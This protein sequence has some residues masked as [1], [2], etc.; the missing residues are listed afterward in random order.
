MASSSKGSL[1]VDAIPLH[2]VGV[3]LGIA[4]HRMGC[5]P[6]TLSGNSALDLD[7]DLA[8]HQ[9]GEELVAEGGELT[10]LDLQIVRRFEEWPGMRL[11]LIAERF[12]GRSDEEGVQT[13]GP[14]PLPPACAAHTRLGVPPEFLGSRQTISKRFADHS[15]AKHDELGRPA[16]NNSGPKALHQPRF[17]ILQARGNSCQ[18]CVAIL[19]LG[20][21]A[22]NPSG[23]WETSSESIVEIGHHEQRCLMG[24]LNANPGIDLNQS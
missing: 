10:G 5:P 17:P 18:Q 22:A 20:P 24:F 15:T 7:H 11:K 16:S 21:R 23:A 9:F 8:G 3:H 2:S 14:N 4:A 19:K 6:E 13:L 1:A 12:R